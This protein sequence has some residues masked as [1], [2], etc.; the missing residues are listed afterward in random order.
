MVMVV[1]ASV[2]QGDEHAG[3]LPCGRPGHVEHVHCWIE[4]TESLQLKILFQNLCSLSFKLTA[5]VHAVY[6]KA[7]VFYYVNGKWAFYSSKHCS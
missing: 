5:Y 4:L 1:L 7:C 3:A 2:F 6:M